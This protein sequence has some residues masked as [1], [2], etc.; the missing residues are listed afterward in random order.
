MIHIA[1]ILYV[2]GFAKTILIGT[3]TEI[4]FICSLALKLRNTL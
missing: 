3:T 4:Q 2:T 1:T